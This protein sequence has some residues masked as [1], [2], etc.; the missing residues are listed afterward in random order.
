MEDALD[1]LEAEGVI[2]KI[3][4]SDWAAPI[5]TV[6]KKDGTI[7]ICGDYKVTVNPV[8]EGD[9]YP[10][11]RIEDLFAKLT[12]GKI[13]TTLDMTHAYH[14]LVLDSESQKYVVVNTH[15]GL[16]QY[17]RLPFGIASAPSQF[18]RIMDQIL[19]GMKHVDD[20]IITGATEEEHLANLTEVLQRFREQR[21]RL[22]REKCRFMRKS[23]DYMG[24]RIDSQGLHA[25]EDKL[26]AITQAP[27][28]TNVQELRAFL[29][30]MNYSS[31]IVLRY[32]SLFTICSAET[33]HGSGLRST[34]SFSEDQGHPCILPC[35]G[36]L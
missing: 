13:F 28:P 22:K 2:E 17:K 9:K 7:R 24:H 23:V 29:G 32:H 6:P 8:L 26:D 20:I 16:Y 34:P 18:Q 3:T 4:Y 31:P 35:V 30:L 5:V 10:L 27:Q 21:I 25:T 12:G 11:P 14:Q 36:T 19:Q 1:H 33:L 15:R